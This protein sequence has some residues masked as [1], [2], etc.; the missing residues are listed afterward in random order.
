MSTI[1]VDTIA[2]RTGS[3]NITA[4]NNIAGNLVGNQSGGTVSA[5]NITASGTLGVTGNTTVGGTLVNTGLITASG[6]VAIGGTDAAHTLD[7]YEEGTFTTTMTYDTTLTDTSPDETMTL[8]GTYTKI[9]DMCTV[10]FPSIQ[11]SNQ[12]SGTSVIIQKFTAPF[13]AADNGTVYCG[14][15]E[16]YNVRG[17]YGGGV[18]TQGHICVNIYPNQN[19]IGT[20]F[21]GWLHNGGGYV[22][23]DN[24]ASRFQLSI[25][26]KTA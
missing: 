10:A 18:M 9:G 13:T 8:T 11:R 14:S 15:C 17:R 4:S 19:V 22:E 6:G 25:T 20:I 16:S 24:A 5:T 12:F 7:D 23:L 2:T 3:G 21:E 26:Y 1:K